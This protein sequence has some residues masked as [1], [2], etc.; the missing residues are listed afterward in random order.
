MLRS[1][2]TMV[3]CTRCLHA[4]YS[5]NSSVPKY[6]NRNNVRCPSQP[7]NIM[8][9][10]KTTNDGINYAMPTKSDAK[11]F[12]ILYHNQSLNTSFVPPPPN[13]TLPP[14][15]ETLPP[16][17]ETLPPPNEPLPPPN[18]PL[19]PPNDPSPP[20]LPTPLRSPNEPLS[21]PQN[22]YELT[23]HRTH[24]HGADEPITSGV[25]E[26][27]TIDQVNHDLVSQFDS[28][29]IGI[30]HVL[31][32][33]INITK[34][35]DIVIKEKNNKIKEFK[36]DLRRYKDEVDYLNTEL[37]N[38]EDR[39]YSYTATITDLEKQLKPRDD[40]K[41]KSLEI[42]M[43]VVENYRHIMGDGPYKALMDTLGTQYNT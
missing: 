35:Q 4:G 40:D 23:Q 38:M 21:L 27:Q 3:Y 42:I 10:D 13:E 37:D 7:W 18:E 1:I 34:R 19:P 9:W 28:N 20:P 15:N 11:R 8:F 12:K 22:A 14:P 36:K 26:E 32:N 41:G 2:L 6:H 33:Y 39:L 5:Y 30:R 17:N 25:D 16:P 24:N 43:D 31:D 29:F